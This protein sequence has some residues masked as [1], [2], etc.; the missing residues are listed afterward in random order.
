MAIT[1]DQMLT[2]IHDHLAAALAARAQNFDELTEGMNDTPTFQVY[3]EGM[4][5]ASSESAT[6]T[7]TLRSGVIQETHVIHVDY[8]ARQRSHLGEDMA[9]LVVGLDAICPALEGAGCPPFGLDGIKSFQWSWSRV[10][11]DYAAVAYVGVR[12]VLRLRTF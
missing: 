2:A 5:P 4:D 9:A 11:F 1:Y 7:F 12:F 6:Q 8:Y 3:P 10:L